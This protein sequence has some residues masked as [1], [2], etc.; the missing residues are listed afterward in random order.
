MKDYRDLITVYVIATEKKEN[1]QKCL[2]ALDNQTV[3]FTLD[4]I[5]DCSPMPVAFNQMATRCKTPYFIQCD[6]DMILN[7]DAI[8]I[9]ASNIPFLN[10]LC[11]ICYQLYDHHLGKN[12]YG[13]KI[14][15]TNIMKKYSFK[16]VLACERDLM[17][18]LIENNFN[19][20]DKEEVLGIHSPYWTKENIFLHYKNF[21]Q[22]EKAFKI[23]KN[24]LPQLCDL[25]KSNPSELNL[26][27]LMGACAGLFSSQSNKLEERNNKDKDTDLELLSKLL[28]DYYTKSISDNGKNEFIS[29]DIKNHPYMKALSDIIPIEWATSWEQI[30]NSPKPVILWNGYRYL[31][32]KEAEWEKDIKIYTKPQGRPIYV[33]ERGALPDTIFID[34]HGFLNDSSSYNQTKWDNTLTEEENKLIEQYMFDFKNNDTSLEPQ[35]RDRVNKN[36]FLEKLDIINYKIKV[37]VPLQVREDTTILKWSDWV[38]DVDNFIDII[39]KIARKTPDIVFLV[40]NHP[41]EKIKYQSKLPNVKIVD[42]F[43]YKDCLEYSD[44]VLTINSGVGLQAMIFEKPVIIVGEAFYY[45]KDINYKVLNKEELVYRLYNHKYPNKE[46][47][48]RF[49]YYLK[50]VFYSSVIIEQIRLGATKPKEIIEVKFEQPYSDKQITIKPKNT[51]PAKIAILLTTFLRDELLYQSIDS[52]KKNYSEDYLLL[53]ADQGHKT[54]QK[55]L[56]YNNL[57][58]EINC[59]IYWLPFDCGIS[60]ARNYLVQQANQLEIPYCLLFSDSLLFA[61]NYNWKP[62]I[63]F[64]ESN[65]KFGLVGFSAKNEPDTWR[66]T[67]TLVP[68]QYFLVDIPEEKPIVYNG[69]NLLPVEMVSNFFLSKTKVLLDNPWDDELKLMEFEDFFWRLKTT[70]NYKVFYS[71]YLESCYIP[72]MHNYGEYK[73]FRRRSSGIYDKLVEKKYHIFQWVKKTEAFEKYIIQKELIPAKIEMSSILNKSYEKRKEES[74]EIIIP[75]RDLNLLEVIDEYGE[76]YYFNHLEMKKY[77]Q[78]FNIDCITIKELDSDYSTFDFKKYNLI[79]FHSPDIYFPLSIPIPLLNVIHKNNIPIIG[80]YG[81]ESQTSYPSNYTNLIVSLSLLYTPTLQKLYHS[82][83]TIW[84]PK[85]VDTEYFLPNKFNYNRFAVGWAGSIS[86]VKRIDLLDRLNYPILKHLAQHTKETLVKEINLEPMKKFYKDID[87]LIL[88]SKSEAT[89]RVVLEAMACGLPVVST[90]VG[91][92]R[93]FLEPQWLIPTEN[94]NKIISDINKCLEILQKNPQLRKQV[95]ER[96]RIW[97]E[98]YFSCTII[99]P[100]WDK[101]L[102]CTCKKDYDTIIEII[103]NYLRQFRDTININPYLIRQ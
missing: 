49:L 85:G 78:L 34:K 80:G 44:I 30:A 92:V 7:P 8:E 98:N 100:L 53:I 40:K 91:S 96:N 66:G 55:E 90:D 94:E 87:V 79:Y 6:E 13:I 35:D 72:K 86:S 101:I 81:R 51:K 97:V 62:I 63:D 39:E 38:K 4:T 82:T 68:N 20:L 2:S 102:E 61:E 18:Q 9:L 23:H 26:F 67:I 32:M 47:V 24:I 88:V 50:F 22:R 37:F 31:T 46:K 77:S 48:K 54:N 84:M 93:L 57:K 75:K 64:L 70:T 41:I 17:N 56:Y 43:H 25:L 73:Q 95:G 14:Y 83:K 58:K 11:Q 42:N 36:L 1:Y 60:Y 27:A 59:E 65:Q 12:I 103:N 3:S 45:F 28:S 21:M 76:S 89:P 19:V 29:Y 5:L 69:I 10:N 99:Q 33:V 15:Q 52:I 71:D 74:N 16:N